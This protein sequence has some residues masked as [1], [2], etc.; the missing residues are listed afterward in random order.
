MFAVIAPPGG[1]F[2]L[3]VL[4]CPGSTPMIPPD[5]ARTN[6]AIWIP[7]PTAMTSRA[8]VGLIDVPMSHNSPD[9]FDVYLFTCIINATDN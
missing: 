7:V 4:T 2:Q 5:T 3:A 1:E 8:A 9:H 6:G